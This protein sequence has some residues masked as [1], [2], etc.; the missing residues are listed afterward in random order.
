MTEPMTDR[1]P[2]PPRASGFFAWRT[3]TLPFDVVLDWCRDLRGPACPDDPARLAESLA[4]D[5]RL[6]RE[7]LRTLL[8]RPDV[9][10]ALFVASPSLEERTEVW[11]RDPDGAEGRDV[12]CAIVRYVQRMA[13]RATP[14]G[15]FAGCS[16]GS[17]DR[18]TRLNLQEAGRYRKRS[19]L[20]FDYLSTLVEK[21]EAAPESRATLLYRPNSSLYRSAGRFRYAEE[22]LAGGGRSYHLVAVDVTDYLVAALEGPAQGAT[23]REIAEAIARVRPDVTTPEAEEYVGELI[24]S[25]ILTSELSP[26]VTGPEAI[27]ALIADAGRHSAMREVAG[28]L[29]E[30]RTMLGEMDA[31]APGADLDRYRALARLLESLPAPVEPAR[32]VQVDLIKPAAAASL[33]PEVLSEIQRGVEILR[34]LTPVHGQ[35]DL[36]RFRQAFT[37]RYEEREVPLVEVLDEEVGI[38]FGSAVRG[39]AEAE[40]LLDA[41]ALVSPPQAD[42]GPRWGEKNN[43]L[44]E[45]LLGACAEGTTEIT[46]EKEDLEKLS[47]DKPTALPAAFEVMASIA[48]S[49]VEALD[50]GEFHVLLAG[51]HGPSGARVLGRFCHADEALREGVAAHLRAEE[52]RAPE[53]VFAEV[54]HLPEGRMGNILFRPV[55]REYEISFLGRSGAAPEKQIPV[56]D[57]MVSV[58]GERIVLRSRRL[59]REVI[60][61]LTSAHNFSRRS[62]P[63]YR[64]LCTLQ[65]QGVAEGLGWSWGPLQNAPF[66]PR[67]RSGRLVLSRARWIVPGE[68]LKALA[69]EGDAHRLLRMRR[70]RAQ[71]RLPRFVLLSDGDNELPVDLENVLSID[72]FADIVRKR[73][74]AV[75]TEMFPPPDELCAT[76][77]EGRFVHELVVP[78]V[79]PAVHAHDRATAHPHA[80]SHVHHDGARGRARAEAGSLLHAAPLA[81]HGDAEKV[82]RSFSPGSE[83]L[84]AKIYTGTATADRLLVDCLGPVVRQATRAGAVDRWFFIRYGDPEWHLRLR[85]HG[86]PARLAGE[87]LPA[88]HAALTPGLGDGR[89]WRLQLDTYEREI[90]RYGGLEGILVAEEAFHADSEAVLEIVGMLGG[91][92]GSE[93]R[94]RLALWGIDRLLDDLGLDPEKKLSWARRRKESFAHE[95]RVDKAKRVRL[96]NKFRKERNDLEALF[97]AGEKPDGGDHELGPGLAVLHA[98]SRALTEVAGRLRALAAS[99][100]LTVSME[101]MAAHLAHMRSNRL[102]RSAHRAQEAV[103]YDFLERIYEGRTARQKADRSRATPARRAAKTMTVEGDVVGAQRLGQT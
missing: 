7:R 55:L 62:L 10:E 44:L 20:D 66:L 24:D 101:D 96:G 52:A 69:K 26:P 81:H 42:H 98:C 65:S 71:R 103:L 12:E 18:L 46:L 34:R 28:R 15:L 4:D 22:R 27:D 41:L 49:S 38:G 53:A 32:L 5:R 91:D 51:I 36:A 92:S 17:L 75:L 47:Q 8:A 83:W 74:S 90:E 3:A 78:F 6:L 25:Q 23:C 37:G 67:V 45:R 77:P 40:P 80:D 73:S 84:Y 99:R 19:R 30:A 39:N 50:R 58:V 86:S 70:W 89:L 43:V 1:I 102:L 82:G 16:V 94:W 76:G 95:F 21:L 88:L 33:G 2:E 61:R 85:L 48:S 93:A 63:L 56:S 9:R 87:V 68:E 54:V 31:A 97:R 57:L 13:A 100:R 14:F 11:R 60:P 72:A 35:E 29:D 64:F 79:L 59:G